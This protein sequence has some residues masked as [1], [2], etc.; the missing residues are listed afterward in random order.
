MA[1]SLATID[2]LRDSITGRNVQ[3]EVRTATARAGELLVAQR[4]SWIDDAAQSLLE[5]V[6]LPKNWNSYGEKFKHV[7]VPYHALD[8]RVCRYVMRNWIARTL[9][10]NTI[11]RTTYINYRCFVPQYKQRR[12]YT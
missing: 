4:A 9:P 2:D 3:A 10:P 1:A 11:P 6:E 8:I 12:C 7:A 5:L